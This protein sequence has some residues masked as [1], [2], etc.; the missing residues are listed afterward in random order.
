VAEL[1]SF[2]IG[3][4]IAAAVLAVAYVAFGMGGDDGGSPTIRQ[5]T[6]PPV[7]TNRTT[8][9]TNT[10]PPGTTTTPSGTTQPTQAVAATQPAANPTATR[11][12]VPIA[13]A[14]TAPAATQPP[15]ATATP[16]G[17]NATAYKTTLN[18]LIAQVDYA[19]GV[20]AS[21]HPTDANWK[22]N[23]TLAAQNIQALASSL[24]SAP[25]PSCA[26]SV[27]G[28]VTSGANTAKSAAGALISAAN[29]GDAG[30]ASATSGQF[31]SALQSLTPALNSLGG[32][33]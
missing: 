27:H 4:T 26:A 2:I 33:G 17:T 30:A 32:C 19:R 21:P 10:R 23:A 18:S 20:S 8:T 11:T 29:A 28:S 6:T 24:T 13:T 31:S 15:A 16:A 7:T 5:L 25:P 12:A 14:T 22:Q 3:V 9:P 1:R